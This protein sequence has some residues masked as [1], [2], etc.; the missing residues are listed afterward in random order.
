M[1]TASELLERVTGAVRDE[2]RFVR[3]GQLFDPLRCARFPPGETVAVSTVRDSPD[4]CRVLEAA[5]IGPFDYGR[6]DQWAAYAEI[7]EAFSR[8]RGRAHL[9]PLSEALVAAPVKIVFADDSAALRCVVTAERVYPRRA[10]LG[11]LS[12]FWGTEAV[13]AVAGILNSAVGTALYCQTAHELGNRSDDLAK[14]ILERIPIPLPSGAHASFS[15]VARLSYRL[16]TLHKARRACGLDL[17]EP[18]RDHWLQLLPEVVHLYGWTE[19]EA[20][21]L[22]SGA[23]ERGARDLPSRQQEHQPELFGRDPQLALRPVRLLD[24]TAQ[25]R[26]DELKSARRGGKLTA[27]ERQELQRLESLLLWEDRLNA[28]VP[29]V[30]A[31]PA[32]SGAGSEQQALKA[33]YRHLSARRGQRF[34]AENPVRRSARLWEVEVYYSPPKGLKS[35]EAANVP[36]EWA[37]PGKHPAGRLY[38]DAA[39]GKAYETLEDA[40]HAIG[41]QP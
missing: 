28:P 19:D 41:P 23:K 6:R 17:E 30:L 14:G 36:S 21:L 10:W 15:N 37:V 9:T 38:V 12:S 5:D 32:W 29:A 7:R 16:H 25:R 3:L 40:Q 20:R 26:C 13:F 33:A 2:R 18:I 22:L 39:T 8:S 35:E 27:E 4:H 31:A 34:G 1:P 24:D 11:A